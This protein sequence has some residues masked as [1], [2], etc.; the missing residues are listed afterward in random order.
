MRQFTPTEIITHRFAESRRRGYDTL[1]VDQ[2]LEELAEYMGHLHRQVEAPVNDELS[3]RQVI[4]NAHQVA[5]DVFR[6]AT[7]RAASE[8]ELARAEIEQVR[9][10]AQCAAAS[11]VATAQRQAQRILDDAF[12]RAQTVERDASARLR[13]LDRMAGEL[14]RF[15]DNSTAELRSKASQM[16]EMADQLQFKMMTGT[17][18]PSVDDIDIRVP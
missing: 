15:V 3:T 18:S 14:A 12:A 1:A 9:R 8:L 17:G 6:E 16:Q 10:D 13:D 7:D 11:V 5:D 2:Y 4:A